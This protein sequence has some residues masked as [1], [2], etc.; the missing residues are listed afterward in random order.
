[1]ITGHLTAPL[2]IQTR[3]TDGKMFIDIVPFG[4]RQA[5]MSFDVEQSQA[6]ID[7][8]V[9]LRNVQLNYQPEEGE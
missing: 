9:F 2:D 7:K 1:M 3:T 4:Y 5:V 6:L 8:L